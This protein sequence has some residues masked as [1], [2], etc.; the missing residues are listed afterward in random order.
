MPVDF[1]TGSSIP[2]R[3]GKDL[4]VQEQ[5]SLADEA[6]SYLEDLN[7]KKNVSGIKDNIFKQVLNMTKDLG[8]SPM[9]LGLA[10]RGN[11]ALVKVL[12]DR[13]KQHMSDTGDSFVLSYIKQKYPKLAGI[14]SKI[15]TFD[16]AFDPLPVIQGNEIQLSPSVKAAYYPKRNIVV[17]KTNTRGN[18]DQI[19]S[20][21]D[22]LAHELVHA[23]QN[24]KNP[25]AFADYVNPSKGYLEYYN[26]PVE[27]QAR[28]GGAT[29]AE[30]FQDVYK[31]VFQDYMNRISGAL[32]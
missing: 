28:Q 23:N 1:Q 21:V 14:P 24:R 25:T 26:Q 18:P 32:R 2:L 31:Q 6:F 15:S 4:P 17:A 5:P 16:P 10:V 7:K 29:A 3:I 20:N 8:I 13:V 30:T 22:A 12:Q 19:S 27:V 11:P 9:G